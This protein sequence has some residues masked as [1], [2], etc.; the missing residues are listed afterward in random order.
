MSRSGSDWVRDK[1]LNSSAKVLP[2]T[3]TSQ[4]PSWTDALTVSLSGCRAACQPQVVAVVLLHDSIQYELQGGDFLAN[5]EGTFSDL[6]DVA[7][8]PT[9]DLDSAGDWSVVNDTP[10][11]V[12][13][14]NAN[15]SVVLVNIL[16]QEAN[17]HAGIRVPSLPSSILSIEMVVKANILLP[18]A[19]GAD[20]F[21]LLATVGHTTFITQNTT[22]SLLVDS[23]TAANIKN[24]YSNNAPA[25][26]LISNVGEAMEHGKWK[27]VVVVL[28]TAEA[29]KAWSVGIDTDGNSGTYV[30]F[31]FVR[32]WN[33][34]LTSDNVATLYQEVVDAGVYT[35][36]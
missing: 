33:K 18:P 13:K 10:S 28:N 2:R 12:T 27:H 25:T 16:H 20:A 3:I 7:V 6:F 23:A 24:V 26:T 4:F 35:L 17:R 1:R 31:G 9:V 15:H 32:F 14:V 36:A 11:T 34:E 29:G 22:D 8:A 5:V 19:P 30:E 21:V